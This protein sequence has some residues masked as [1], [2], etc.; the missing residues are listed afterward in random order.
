MTMHVG[1]ATPN[2]SMGC[3][4][5]TTSEESGMDEH[6]IASSGGTPECKDGGRRK[7]FI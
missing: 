5:F 2:S 6:K 4:S 3:S 7:E 1:Y